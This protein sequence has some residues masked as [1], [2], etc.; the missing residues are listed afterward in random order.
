LGRIYVADEVLL[1]R[2]SIYNRPVNRVTSL[3]GDRLRY[4]QVNINIAR[5][6]PVRAMCMSRRSSKA[7][8]Y[9]VVE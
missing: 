2:M 6:R 8:A 1:S 9:M 5:K 3:I 4:Y 7:G